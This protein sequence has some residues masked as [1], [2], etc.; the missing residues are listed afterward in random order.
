MSSLS[1]RHRLV[2][3]F[4]VAATALLLATG[5]RSA[6]FLPE[7]AQP[8]SRQIA[9]TLQPALSAHSVPGAPVGIVLPDGTVV[10]HY[11]GF[12]RGGIPVDSDTV[13]QIASVSKPVA[14][15]V[16]MT[17]V[18]DREISLDTPVLN[19][20]GDWSPPPS[21]FDRH[22]V[23]VRQLLSHRGGLSVGGYYGA[24]VVPGGTHHC[25][26]PCRKDIRRRGS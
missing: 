9:G 24:P 3:R 6:L 4:S 22:E 2:A 10:E 25:R 17:L 20:A 18:E 11:A 15:W 16:V 7:S 26:R 12:A 5:C 14:A 19:P 8:V 13:F 21:R 23:T 1:T